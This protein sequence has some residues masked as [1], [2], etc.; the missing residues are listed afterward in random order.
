MRVDNRLSQ[1]MCL[2]F[3]TLMVL[4][5]FTSAISGTG[6]AVAW[7]VG[8]TAV[9][10][11]GAVRSMRS[12][13]FEVGATEVRYVTFFG[14]RG[15]AY[16]EIASSSVAVGTS[17]FSVVAREFVVLSLRDGSARS[18]KEASGPKPRGTNSTAVQAASALINQRVMPPS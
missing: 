2:A 18:L 16:P 6:S 3:F 11:A 4:L 10:G 14:A 7:S 12:F 13:Y 1:R 5:E 15:F 17:G 8:L 9:G